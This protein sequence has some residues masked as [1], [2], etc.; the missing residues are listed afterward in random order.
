MRNVSDESYREN[1]KNIFCPI[2][3]FNRAFYEIMWKILY[4]RAGHSLQYGTC[5]LQNG[6]LSV[7]ME[8][9]NVKY[10]LLFH[11]NNVGMNAPQSCVLH[12]LL[13]LFL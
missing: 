4:S 10:I 5:A 11:C 2:T 12:T 8:S 1:K 6:Y 7:K 13:V 3:F 9:Q